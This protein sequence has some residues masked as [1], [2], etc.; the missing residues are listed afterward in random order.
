MRVYLAFSLLLDL[1]MG[2]TRAFEGENGLLTAQCRSRCMEEFEVAQFSQAISRNSQEDFLE[3]CGSYGRCKA[4]VKPCSLA[5]GVL[6]DCESKC[7]EDEGECLKTCNYLRA[8]AVTKPGSCPQA[9]AAIGF[10]A[11]CMESCTADT[12]CDG[13]LKC[14]ANGCGWTCQEPVNLGTGVPAIPTYIHWRELNHRTATLW[15]DD[16]M[17]FSHVP[18]VY[19]LKERKYFNG[20]KPDPNDKKGWVQILQTTRPIA[21]VSISAGYTYQY[22]VA[23]V[24]S[25]G[26]LGFSNASKE[27]R[28]SLEIRDPN[29]PRNLRVGKTVFAGDTQRVTIKWDPPAELDFPITRYKIFYS[30]TSPEY[31]NLEEHQKTVHGDRHSLTLKDLQPG[32]QYLVQIQAIIQVGKKRYRSTKESMHMVTDRPK[33]KA[34]DALHIRSQH[35]IKVQNL[36]VGTPYFHKGNLKAQVYWNIA[37]GKGHKISKYLIYWQ[38]TDNCQ[39]HSKNWKLLTMDEKQEAFSR[40]T[41]FELYHLIYD[42]QYQVDVSAVNLDGRQGALVS[43]NFTTP[44]CE[45]IV[46]KGSVEID[47]PIGEPLPPGRPA[48]PTYLLHTNNGISIEVLWKRPVSYYPIIRYLVHL[49]MVGDNV[50][51][52]E[53]PIV[54]GLNSNC[55]EVVVNATMP[56]DQ[57]KFRFNNLRE[58]TQY[59]VFIYADSKVGRSQPT[60][61]SVKTPVLETYLLDTSPR[62]SDF[63]TSQNPEGTYDSTSAQRGDTCSLSVMSVYQLLVTASLL[64]LLIP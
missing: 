53:P 20:E 16:T 4:C 26:S 54:L 50:A 3:K 13:H 57:T 17:R 56:A 19:I 29:P 45:D 22:E 39:K 30:K 28:S 23:A 59:I 27:F 12:H 51:D 32:T 1:H 11:A 55:T 62:K 6:T 41:N 46:V 47:C 15:W 18:V 61:I 52:K 31:S 5:G 35:N 38:S 36:T 48:R 8:N 2:F 25:Q 33:P 63:S 9:L 58:N 34:V 43:T 44:P 60:K 42:C 21:N 49:V 14:C 64:C 24:S 40:N 7:D 37:P 10:E